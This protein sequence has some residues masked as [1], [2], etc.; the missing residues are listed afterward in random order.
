MIKINGFY[1][2]E[3]CGVF[4]KEKSNFCRKCAQKINRIKKDLNS[5]GKT[6]KNKS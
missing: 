2:C 6:N 4:M 1:V 5:N 3:E